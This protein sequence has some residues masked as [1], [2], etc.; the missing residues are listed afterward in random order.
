MKRTVLFLVILLSLFTILGCNSSS[1]G[2][3][4][5]PE[6]QNNESTGNEQNNEDMPIE[7]DLVSGEYRSVSEE[8]YKFN[9]PI[10]IS[11]M[12]ELESFLNDHP[13]VLS[14]EYAIERNFNNEEF[15]EHSIIYAYI[16]FESSGSNR[17]TINR[18]EL[19]GDT[20]KLYMNHIVPQY[21]TDDDAIR[22]CLFGINNK[23]IK[24]VK[25]VAG[26]VLSKS[27]E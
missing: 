27:A 16:K 13:T 9:T 2:E 21:G 4:K 3:L 25:T 12:D 6:N 20:L 22:I 18:A 23:D 14:K 17:L 19:D 1:D 10:L 5:N 24:N 8:N 7:L 11:S 15:F 26:I